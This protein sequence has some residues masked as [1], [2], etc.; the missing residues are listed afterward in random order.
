MRRMPSRISQKECCLLPVLSHRSPPPFLSSLLT[1]AAPFAFFARTI[2]RRLSTWRPCLASYSPQY[3]H[4]Y[5]RR[6]MSDRFFLMGIMHAS[7]SC[8]PTDLTATDE[9]SV[10]RRKTQSRRLAPHE[11]TCSPAND[12]LLSEVAVLVMMSP[13]LLLQSSSRISRC[14]DVIECHA[15]ELLGPLH[16][17]LD[18]FYV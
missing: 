9:E 1:S 13:S 5:E 2:C 15:S 11:E 16:S 3:C 17:L 6:C 4:C 10:R 14:G 12:G 18:W 7:A 8:C